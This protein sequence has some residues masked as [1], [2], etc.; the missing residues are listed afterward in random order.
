MTTLDLVIIGA[1]A[2][3]IGASRAATKAGLA[4]RVIEASHRVGGRAYTEDLAPGVPFDLGCHWLHAAQRN[5]LVLEA[6]RLGFTLDREFSFTPRTWINGRYSTPAET[7]AYGGYFDD[8]ATRA[9]DAASGGKDTDVMSVL[10]QSSPWL[11]PYAHVFSVVNAA[12]PEEVSAMDVTSNPIYGS[13]WPV[14]QGLGRLIAVLGADLPISLNTVAEDVDW[15]ARDHVT[16]RTNKGALIARTVLITV[17]IGILQ[18]GLIKFRPALP[19]ATV[20][21]IDGLSPGIANRI[22]LHFDRDVFGDAP[23]NFT[24]LD[25]EAE[26]LAIHIPTFGFN[27]VVGQTGGHFAGHLTRAGQ[28]AAIDYVME[29]TVSVFGAD[30]RRHFTRGIVSAWETDP[31]VR[32]AYASVKPGHFGARQSLAEPIGNR[33][34]FAGEA[35]A[36][37]MVAT[38]GGAYKSGQDAVA[39]IAAALRQTA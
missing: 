26:P 11:A 25:G 20:A 5:P 18:S 19:S 10:D 36:I 17:S 38:C 13:D 28:Q 34:F 23:H 39:R 31:W 1:G 12:D 32:G 3:G 8:V 16:V 2:A 30:V 27:Y 15:S 35:V 4:H 22:A 9:Q 29:R 14:R 7:A 24:I 21:A 6:D 33:L 37:P